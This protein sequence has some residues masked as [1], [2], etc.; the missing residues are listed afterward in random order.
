[1]S[2]KQKQ[3]KKPNQ[4]EP[5]IPQPDLRFASNQAKPQERV[6]QSLTCEV[7]VRKTNHFA[8]NNS[9]QSLDETVVFVGTPTK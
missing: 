4:D 1:M 2:S 3:D 5:Q 7:G 9:I 6:Q 8:T